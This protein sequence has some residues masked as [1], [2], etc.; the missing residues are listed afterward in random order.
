LDNQ[1]AMLVAEHEMTWWAQWDCPIRDMKSKKE[2]T[3]VT[4][5]IGTTRHIAE[6]QQEHSRRYLPNSS[7][8]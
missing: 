7:G 1:K 5:D 8:S 4:A 6:H 3:N 2:Q